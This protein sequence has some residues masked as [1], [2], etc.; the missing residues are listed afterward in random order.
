MTATAAKAPDITDARII[1]K[2]RFIINNK[3]GPNNKIKLYAKNPKI[4]GIFVFE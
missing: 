4:K 3:I 2:L 1:N